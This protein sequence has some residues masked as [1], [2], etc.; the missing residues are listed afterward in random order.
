MSH[1]QELCGIEVGKSNYR[2]KSKTMINSEFPNKLH[3][4]HV[5]H[6]RPEVVI[7]LPGLYKNTTLK[8]KED[9]LK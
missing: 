3:Y 9:L 1:L 6:K 8:E 5:G 4:V 7:S 2:I